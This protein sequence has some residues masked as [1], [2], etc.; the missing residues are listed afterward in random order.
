MN[1]IKVLCFTDTDTGRDVEIILPIRYFAERFLNCKFYHSI[2]F[3]A[4]SIYRFKPDIILLPNTIGSNLYFKLSKKAHR[5][6]IPLFALISEGNFRTNGTFNYWGFN[7]DKVFYQEY[8]CCWSERTAN[9]L[10]SEV[11]EAEEKIVV[12]GGTGFDRYKIYK[13][14]TR[15]EILKKYNLPEFKKV[16]G[17]AGWAFGKL[18]HKR[19]RKELTSAYKDNPEK[20]LKWVAEQRIL[21]RDILRKS[22]EKNK[23]TLFILKRHPQE[24]SPELTIEIINEMSELADYDNVLYLGEEEALHD[25]INISDLWTCFESTT[26]LEAWL[27]GKETIFINPDPNF[28]RDQLFKGSVLVNSYENLQEKINEYFQNGKIEDFYKDEKIS[29]REKIIKETI[30]FDDGMNHIRAGYYLHKTIEKKLNRK[31]TST[32][33]F[34]FYD[35]LI[36]LGIRFFSLFYNRNI[37][38]HIYKLK[39]HLWVFEDFKLKK[40]PV[41]YKQY[42]KYLN[43]FYNLNDVSNKFKKGIL[44]KELNLDETKK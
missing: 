36:F 14:K 41:L 44:Y 4:F 27:L 29:A 39:K 18:Q 1:K 31:I 43:E 32:Y 25:L 38:K 19:G 17:Y 21:V 16:I 12:T 8:V 28:N 22:I 34:N 40:I 20:R 33:R 6:N 7:T 42:S 23:D 24:S 10:K 15:E 11:P 9:F 30:G 37:F 5:Q 2:S 35:F 26:A 13:F 3:D